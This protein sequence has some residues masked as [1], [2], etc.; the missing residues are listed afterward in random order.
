M[1][2]LL[3]PRPRQPAPALSGPPWLVPEPVLRELHRSA[4]CVESVAERLP[5]LR[6]H[7]PRVRALLPLGDAESQWLER[8]A[9]PAG[10]NSLLTRLDARLGHDG[11]F[12]FLE[13][14][15]LAIRSVG[16]ADAWEL[17]VAELQTRAFGR[18]HPH[19]AL[20]GPLEDLAQN[21][22]TH[23]FTAQLAHPAELQVTREGGILLEGRPV[24]VVLRDLALRELAA[25][26]AE[27]GPLGGLRAAFERGLVLPGTPAD[28][29]SKGTFELLSSPDFEPFLR[30]DEL[31]AC[32]K[33][34]AWTRLLTERRTTGRRD[35]AIDL[36]RYALR[37]RDELVLKPDRASGGEGVVLGPLVA[38]ATWERAVH[39]ALATSGE[40]VVQSFQPPVQ[41]DSRYLVAGVF[42]TAQGL[43]IL[44][45]SSASPVVSPTR[46]ATVVPVA[47]P[48]G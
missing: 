13:A 38:Q 7:D 15:G 10:R 26:E 40:W 6:R 3:H 45:S 39:E 28:L 2:L 25:I 19:V 8:Y 48:P 21:L 27:H 17:L 16:W 31:E 34:V 4:R 22:R 37:H 23:G 33:H 11:A 44:G 43:A 1:T 42:A 9:H 30:D 5:W 12:V 46:G 41:A 18:R 36:P 32:R 29:D 35:E 47:M 20:L 14:N 24:D